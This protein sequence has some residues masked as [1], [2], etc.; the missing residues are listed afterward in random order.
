MALL[1]SDIFSGAAAHLNDASKT[2]YTDAIQLPFLQTAARD[3]EIECVKHDIQV[4]EEVS[5][6]KDVAALATTLASP[7]ADIIVPKEMW[8]RAEGETLESNWVPMT[9]VTDMPKVDQTETLRYWEWRENLIN[10]LGSSA[11]REIKLVYYRTS[12]AISSGASEASALLHA[13]NY[14]T[15]K[16]AYYCAD[17]IGANEKLAASLLGD[18]NMAMDGLIT[19]G[20][21]D[22]QFQR[23]KRRKYSDKFNK[24]FRGY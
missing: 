14:L 6:V 10:F 5:A 21:K 1:A 19:I 9:R 4:L 24:A 7:P 18:A 23:Y 2:L 13:Q 8:E 22:G 3:L 17:R 16:T 20:V 11:A 15:F 12:A